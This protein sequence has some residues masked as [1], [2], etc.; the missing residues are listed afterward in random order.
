[1]YLLWDVIILSGGCNVMILALA[2]THL[3]RVRSLEIYRESL[4]TKNWKYP[5]VEFK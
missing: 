5:C 3:P 1:M 2:D 4:V